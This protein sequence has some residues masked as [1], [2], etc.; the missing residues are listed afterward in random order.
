[1]SEAFCYW[2]GRL[3]PA[4]ELQVAPWDLGFVQG[5]TVAE[6]LRTFCGKL[7]RV[8]KHLDRLRDSLQTIG[9]EPQPALDE[10]GKIAADLAARNHRLL[11]EGD[12][13]GLS[14]FC[15]PGPYR[16]FIPQ[17]VDVSVP[18]RPTVGMHTYPVAFGSFA[19]KYR[20]GERLIISHTRQV[21][22]N[23]W[24][25]SLKC[26]S[27]MHYYLADLEARRQDPQARA[28]LLD[29]G[30]M[31]SEASTANFLIYRRDEGFVSPPLD[32]ILPGVSVD[33]LEGIARGLR[34]PFVYRNISVPE[35]L[36]AD[37][38]FLSSTSP[39]LLPVV[40]VDGQTLGDGL[41]G[42]IFRRTIAAWSELVGCDIV[43]Q[44]QR[45]AQR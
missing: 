5:V 15:T 30:G 29:Q 40:S 31:V 11:D 42:P 44:A 25:A 7:F 41:P 38:A 16:A 33:S 28:L 37:E 9:V 12:D 26:R 10:L 36:A 2:N 4:R 24:P 1:M 39:C 43:G 8:E 23:C 22:A 34:I 32:Q 45:F 19:S 20:E 27:R 17:G 13:L 3:M 6:Q 14:L 21:P 18:A 35:V